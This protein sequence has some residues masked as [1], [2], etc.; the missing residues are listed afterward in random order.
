MLKL[1]NFVVIIQK[2]DG[3]SDNFANAVLLFGL[4]NV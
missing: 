1:A 2:R 4:V 3:F